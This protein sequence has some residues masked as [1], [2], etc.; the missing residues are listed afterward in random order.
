MSKDA[1]NHIKCCSS[2]QHRKTSHRTPK[3]PVGDRPVSRPF[4]CVAIDFVEYKW[5]SN[6]SKYGMS[7][8]DHVTRL[9]VLV[10]FSDRSAATTVRVVV[11]CVFSVMSQ[12]AGTFHLD[13]GIEFENGL[14][15]E[16]QSVSGFKK[17]HTS[18]YHR[19][20]STLR[21]KLAMYVN[22][23]HDNWAELLPFLQLAD[24]T[25]Y[26]KTL[27]ETLHFFYVWP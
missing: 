1:A 26:K 27:E 24:N 25:T 21:N 7:V 4:Q 3:L 17:T 13:Q 6:N 12:P 23:E 10:T 14:V 9:R 2:C 8:I 15:K 19:A 5:S 22:V 20:R 16:L 11:E 18:A